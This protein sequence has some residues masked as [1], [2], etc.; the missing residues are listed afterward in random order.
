M[1]ISNK[2]SSLVLIPI[3]TAVSFFI[4]ELANSQATVS[5]KVRGENCNP[6]IPAEV[7][8]RP[9]LFECN[10]NAAVLL[11]GSLRNNYSVVVRKNGEFN[12]RDP[13]NPNC[14]TNRCSPFKTQK[15]I[16]LPEY[17]VN[18]LGETGFSANYQEVNRISIKF[19]ALITN[20]NDP[21]QFEQYCL[22]SR[23]TNLN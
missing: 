19:Q 9:S 4:P 13:Q 11:R 2:V 6:N 17:Q 16:E 22:T 8:Y 14:G 1:K 12:D 15:R 3:M 21:R 18:C 20:A 7:G 23:T 5:E 10:G